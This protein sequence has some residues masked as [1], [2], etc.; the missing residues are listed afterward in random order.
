MESTPKKSNRTRNIFI[1]L[2]V[3]ALACVICVAIVAVVAGGAVGAIAAP[4]L[5]ANDFMTSLEA[6]DY[7]KAYGFIDPSQQEGFGGSADGMQAKLSGL[8][9]AEPTAHTLSNINVN[10]GD[11]VASGTATFGGTIQRIRVDMRKSGD[12]WLVIGYGPDNTPEP[13]A[14]S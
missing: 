13:T 6:K 10:N 1:V 12:N 8:G 2:G 4:L 11:A 5:K 3:L 14:T 7:A 9:I